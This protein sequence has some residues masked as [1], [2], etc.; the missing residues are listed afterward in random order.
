[1]CQK[2]GSSWRNIH[3]NEY[4]EITYPNHITIYNKDMG[5]VGLLHSLLRYYGNKILSKKCYH[6]ILF[7]L[8]DL[9]LVNEFYRENMMQMI[10]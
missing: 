9:I 6:R 4:I 10:V 5:D 1:M 7:H 8:T 2:Q 3:T